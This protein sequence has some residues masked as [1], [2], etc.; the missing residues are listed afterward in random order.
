MKHFADRWTAAAAEKKAPVCVGLDPNLT[1]MPAEFQGGEPLEQIERFCSEV[2]DIVAPIVPAVKPQMAYFEAFG[3]AG[4]DLYFRLSAKAQSLGLLVIGDAKRGDIGSTSAAYAQRHLQCD[5]SPDALTVNGYF[6]ADGTQPFIDAAADT[7]RGL[8]VLVRTSNPSST[9]VQNVEG[10]D[11]RMF[12]E[13]MASVVA[14]MGSATVGEC[15]YSHV[16]A[17]VGATCPQEAR[18]LRELMPE[19]IFLVPG[20]GA[21]GAT[22]DDCAASFKDGAGAMVNASRSVLYPEPVDGCW[23][24]GVEAAAIAFAQDIAQAVGVR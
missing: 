24:K 8:F 6:G 18:V 15:G 16:G 20:Y 4:M 9:V 22:A 1:R 14:A 5:D 21:Q 17:V 13:H 7:G 19:Q 23:K 3:G 11:G 12:Y 10:T 2:L